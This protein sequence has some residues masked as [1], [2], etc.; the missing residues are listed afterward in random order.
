MAGRRS[1]L[2][3]VNRV[4][5]LLRRLP[6]DAT[7]Q[8]ERVVAYTALSIQADAKQG[9]PIKDGNLRDGIKVRRNR[10]GLTARIGYVLKRDRRKA[11]Y[12]IFIHWGTKHLRGNPFLWNA[13]ARNKRAF[14]ERS[15]KAIKTALDIASRGAGGNE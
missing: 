7:Q 12:A 5:R 2:R 8:I 11:F 3:K 1:G 13:A 14:F 6:D 4:R 10:D 9:A 15:R